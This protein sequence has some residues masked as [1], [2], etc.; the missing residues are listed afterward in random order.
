MDYVGWVYV[1]C[2]EVGTFAGTHLPHEFDLTPYLQAEAN[3][4]AIIFD[5]PPR[6]LGHFGHTSEMT[7]WKT[8]FNYTWDWCPRLVQTGIWDTISLSAVAGSALHDLRVDTDVDLTDGTGILELSGGATSASGDRVRVRLERE[9]T[10]LREEEYQ[11]S[12]LAN[13]ITW[14]GLP[15]EMWWPNLEGEHPLY[16]VTCALLDADGREHDRQTLRVGFKHVEW[17]PCEGAPPEADPWLCVVNGRPIFLQGVNFA[18]LSAN[19]ADLTHADYVQR[20]RQYRDLG[21]NLFRINACQFRERAWFYDL[22]DEMGLMVWQEFPITSSGLE[23]W[24]PEDAN[25]IKAMA[26][27]AAS[28]IRLRRHHV[29]LLLW[30][31]SNEQMGAMDGGKAG[32][33]KPC[34]L[35]HPLLKRLGD[36][37]QALDP[38]RRYIPTSPLGPRAWFDVADAG[39]GL[40][41]DV[42]G[43]AAMMLLADAEAQWAADDAL[44]RAEVYCPGASSVDVIEKYAGDFATWPATAD[45]PY[46]TRLTTW[47][48]DWER[49]VA[50]HGREPLELAEYV[51]WSQANQ[52]LM[53]SREMQTC[54]ARFPRCGGVLMWS[55][56]DTFPLTINSSL[57]DFDGHLKAA[58]EAVRQVWRTPVTAVM[59]DEHDG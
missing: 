2:R 59:G 40:H 20:L 3:E 49:L 9:G 13:G 17:L 22:C 30:S 33:G 1:N 48:L 27:I 39:K 41:W 11:P 56:H 6:W 55:G 37:V 52:A 51:A 15:V 45:N 34:D 16:T 35:S 7:E 53:I 43:G 29:S 4:L 36:V 5:L 21:V 31:G 46:W 38:R 14:S 57:I 25:S 32:M 50:I 42:H 24:P 44:F 12:A 19:Y 10:I 26:E 28:F 18:P 8:R 23:N 47:W 54:K 58:A